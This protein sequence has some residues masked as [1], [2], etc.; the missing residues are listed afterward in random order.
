M[1]VT[2]PTRRSSLRRE[3]NR[4]EI[5]IPAKRNIFLLLFL[6]VW[7]VGWCL[8]EVFAV[9]ALLEQDDAPNLFLGVWL[10]GWT[11]GG[12]AALSACLWML[13][14]REVIGLHGDALAI[15]HDLL[16]L[17]RTREYDLQHIMNLRVA[18]NTWNPYDWS[19]GMQFWGIGGGLIAFDYGSRTVRVGNS[20]DEA[21]ARQIVQDL[22]LQHPFP[23]ASL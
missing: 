16:G 9:R 2:P 15:R 20:I 19:A 18:P 12:A 5:S 6:S 22:K 7:L 10:L 1:R 8:G 17:G 13:K 4:L 3:G 11:V 21:E 23:D 14:G